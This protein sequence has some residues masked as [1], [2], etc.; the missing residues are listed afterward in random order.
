MPG[1]KRVTAAGLAV[2]AVITLAVVAGL[3]AVLLTDRTGERGSG[4]GDAYTYDYSEHRE[5]DPKLLTYSETGS[6]PTGF[7]TS[8]GIAVGTSGPGGEETVYVAGDRG[9]RGFALGTS[10]G[11]MRTE[12]ALDGEPRCLAVV[13][14]GAGG[15]IYVGMAD[16]VNRFAGVFLS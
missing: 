12:F 9:A 8:R 4:L 10:E 1:E 15:L 16:H 11:R 3:L 7:G 5:I 14:P 6:I 2:G 13:G